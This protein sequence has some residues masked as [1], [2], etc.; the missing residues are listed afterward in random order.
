MTRLSDRPNSALLVVDVQNDVMA[1]AVRRDEVVAN[2]SALV[3]RA[4][5]SE[6]AVVWVQHADDDLVPDTEGWAIVDELVPDESELLIHKEYGDSFEA[7][8]LEAELE[9]RG[10][11]RLVVTGAQTDFCIRS[12][13]HSAFTRGYDTVLV[14]DAHSTDDLSEH[15]F[16]PADKVIAHTNLYWKGQAGPGREAT[17]VTTESVDLTS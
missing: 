8:T 7:T 3:E 2:I 6:V 5:A 16:P 9:E 12:T 14:G 11:G 4:R 13:I 15:G 1:N 17:V 10:I